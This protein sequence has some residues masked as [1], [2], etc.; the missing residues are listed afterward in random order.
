MKPYLAWNWQC[1]ASNSE[2][3][4]PLSLEHWDQG[5]CTWFHGLKDQE[6]LHLSE[7]WPATEWSL[8]VIF[9]FFAA[10]WVPAPTQI[11]PAGRDEA[12]VTL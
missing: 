4:P 1:L 7:H 11:L 9:T 10:F 2:I 12:D 6:K 8:H 3:L 5:A